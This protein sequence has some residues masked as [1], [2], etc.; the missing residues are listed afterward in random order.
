MKMMKPDARKIL[1]SS[2]AVLSSVAV[3]TG[4][5]F[6][7]QTLLGQGLAL[8]LYLVAVIV[9]SL[10]FGRIAGIFTTLLAVVIGSRLFLKID[11]SPV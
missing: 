3:I 11:Y 5:R 9:T 10:I 2:L 1:L 8:T 4:L 7:L 6:V